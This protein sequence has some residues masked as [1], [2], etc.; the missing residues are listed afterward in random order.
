ML[1]KCWERI[2]WRHNVLWAMKASAVLHVL[3]PDTALWEPPVDG[4][5]PD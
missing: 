2:Y 1:T 3:V 4:D 5:L